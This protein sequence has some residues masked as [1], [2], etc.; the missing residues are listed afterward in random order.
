MSARRP[1]A[2]PLV[3]LYATVS[4]VKENFRGKPK[5][6][7]WP[8]INV[9][10]ISAGGAGKTP[11]VI[12]LAKL[13]RERGH[14][15]DILTRGYGRSGSGIGPERY[16]PVRVN[17]AHENAAEQFGDEPVL[18]EH[19]TNAPVFVG[20]DRYAAGQ[21]AEQAAPTGD[22]GIHILDDGFQHRRLARAIDIALITEEDLADHLIPAGNLR[23]PIS[24]LQRADILL[25]REEEREKIEKAVT[26]LLRPGALLWS[27]H[28]RLHFPAPL[29]VLSAGLRPL[30]F[31]AIA[32]PE[33]FSLALQAAGCG[34]VDTV[35]F[36]D[37]QPYTSSEVSQLLTIAKHLNASG[38]VT[39]E[40]DAVKL[41][42]ELRAELEAI[43]PLVV[44]PL[45]AEFVYPERTARELEA[46]LA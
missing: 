2:L 14:H 35:A 13:L 36:R 15:V 6:L 28:R 43:G 30:A 31:C 24:A 19:S 21:L 17:P 40:K 22:R 46:R 8:V 12:A 18:I 25:I 3:P 11:V 32:R 10:S 41:S 20:A 9:G 34:I 29:G 38:F 1:W 42:P 37:H 45:V 33:G 5:Q 4:R 16:K 23:E 39:T 27:V 44:V 26:K 7:A